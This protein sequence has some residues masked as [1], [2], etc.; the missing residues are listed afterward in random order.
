MISSGQG[1]YYFLS[2]DR[3]EA[4]AAN[5]PT[6][7]AHTTDVFFG[8]PPNVLF[9]S[10]TALSQPPPEYQLPGPR[11]SAPRPTPPLLRLYHRGGRQRLWLWLCC[12][13][14]PTTMLTGYGLIIRPMLCILLRVRVNH[15]FAEKNRATFYWVEAV[16]GQPRTQAIYGWPGLPH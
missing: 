11:A 16:R 3:I 8:Y 1:E 12:V 13:H 14:Y 2:G 5:L 6:G 10:L 4:T 15:R 7:L 9:S